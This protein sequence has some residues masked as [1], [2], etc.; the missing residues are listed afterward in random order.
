MPLKVTMFSLVLWIVSI[1]AFVAL[2]VWLVALQVRRIDAA[3]DAWRGCGLALGWIERGER[4]PRP[5]VI[6]GE[7]GDVRVEIAAVSHGTARA[8]SLHT[9]VSVPLALEPLD[10]AAQRA[11]LAFARKLRFEHTAERFAIE[12]RGLESDPVVLSEAAR[13]V[14]TL[15]SRRATIRHAA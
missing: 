2:A 7:L 9:R 13:L 5:F 6:A 15:A 1:C 11:L 10:D 8:K 12:W 14:S 4:I 3:E